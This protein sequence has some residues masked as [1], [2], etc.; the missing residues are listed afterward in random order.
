MK[1]NVTWNNRIQGKGEVV[2]IKVR[3]RKPCWIQ[4][5]CHFTPKHT[6]RCRSRVSTVCL[7][8]DTDYQGTLLV[9]HMRHAHMGNSFHSG[10][11]AEMGS[12]KSPLS[13]ITV[14]VRKISPQSA[15]ISQSSL[16][17]HANYKI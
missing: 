17:M 15:L 10:F 7:P 12:S 8:R 5:F 6:V 14:R 13:R 4:S 2:E 16:I 3:K 11:F 1:Y 9:R